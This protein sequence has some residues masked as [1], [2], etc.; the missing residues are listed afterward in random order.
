[1]RPSQLVTSVLLAVSVAGCAAIAVKPGAER[2]KLTNQEPQGC[3][4]LGDIS[5]SQGNAITG[6]WTS[7]DSLAEGARNDLKNKGLEKGANV[8]HVLASRDG[9][10]RGGKTSSSME[11][12]A[13]RC[14][15]H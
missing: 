7:N 1:M 10:Q 14:P 12:V 8:I 9:H 2:V 3:E 13:Y 15:T 6:G 4:Y 5:G 11:G